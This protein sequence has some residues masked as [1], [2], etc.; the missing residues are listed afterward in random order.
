MPPF[1]NTCSRSTASKETL[2]IVPPISP[3]STYLSKSDLENIHNDIKD[4]NQH[5]S[6]MISKLTDTSSK[7]DK[8]EEQLTD[9]SSKL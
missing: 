7:P 4:L 5:S 6:A 9:I 8:Q 2:A 1:M 3:T